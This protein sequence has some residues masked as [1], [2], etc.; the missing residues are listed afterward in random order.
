MK[1]IRIVNTPIHETKRSIEDLLENAEN[2]ICTQKRGTFYKIESGRSI[3]EGHIKT[4]L[5]ALKAFTA[6]IELTPENQ[7]KTKV[8]YA[9]EGNRSFSILLVPVGLALFTIVMVTI[10]E[11]QSDGAGALFFAIVVMLILVSISYFFIRRKQKY[12]HEGTNVIEDL[13]RNL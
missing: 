1:K 3:S 8:V 11:S 5:P 13:I 12:T 2:I 7:T 9:V 4:S 6:T 10:A